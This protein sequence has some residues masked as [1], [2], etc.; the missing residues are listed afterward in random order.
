MSEAIEVLEMLEGF[1][2]MPKKLPTV[3]RFLSKANAKKLGKNS[4]YMDI[5][6]T[7]G[8]KNTAGKVRSIIIKHAMNVFNQG[9]SQAQDYAAQ[10]EDDAALKEFGIEMQLSNGRSA[11]SS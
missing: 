9:P 4:D 11:T 7:A 2:G 3:K 1:G 8:G 10:F 5:V 6:T